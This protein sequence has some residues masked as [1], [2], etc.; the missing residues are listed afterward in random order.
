MSR[1]TNHR[2]TGSHT[3]LEIHSPSWSRNLAWIPPRVKSLPLG[4][5]HERA[6]ITFAAGTG[7][8]V[9][10]PVNLDANP[11]DREE[12]DDGGDGDACRQGRRQ[13]KVVLGPELEIAAADVDP[14]EPGHGDGGEGV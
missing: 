3:T 5:L 13:D 1:R 8:F 7:L 12:H 10:P 9:A 2:L 6:G 11:L 14:R 4:Q